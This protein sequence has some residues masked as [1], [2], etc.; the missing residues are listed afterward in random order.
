LALIFRG[1][2]VR[3]YHVA[4]PKDVWDHAEPHHEGLG[5]SPELVI[6]ALATPS[7]VISNT[8]NARN[9]R[10]GQE[11]YVLDLPHLKGAVVVPVRI[12]PE[13][14]VIG[15]ETLP[16]ESRVAVSCYLSKPPPPPQKRLW[17]APPE[18]HGNQDKLQPQL[19]GPPGLG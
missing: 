10:S 15:T 8:S 4:L 18:K 14:E 12:L 2:G 5:H 13:P 19:Q 3:G 9:Q 11:R 7:F 6:R 1:L 17:V 16:A